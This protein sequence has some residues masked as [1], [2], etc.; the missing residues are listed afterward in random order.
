MAEFGVQRPWEQVQTNSSKSHSRTKK[1]RRQKAERKGANVV[2]VWALPEGLAPPE[3]APAVEAAIRA[4]LGFVPTN[5]LKVHTDEDRPAVLEVYPLKRQ[6]VEARAPRRRGA[7][8]PVQPWPTTYWFVDEILHVR[9]AALE[10]RGWVGR[11]ER[12]LDG[13]AEALDAA[14]RA[15]VAA[16]RE[17]W[18]ALT[19]GDR[20]LA[21]ARGWAKALRDVGIA[22][23]RSPRKVKC[24]HAQY[25]HFIGAQVVSPVGGWIR[26]LLDAGMDAKEPPPEAGGAVVDDGAPQLGGRDRAHKREAAGPPG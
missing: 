17:R 13:D 11:L 16:G 8:G 25:A 22:G 10:A 2:T 14:E 26:E 9:I 20:D 23:M 1:Q 19:A 3:L 6:P 12:R 15:H 4:R 18:A 24:L 5:L 7:S 21:E